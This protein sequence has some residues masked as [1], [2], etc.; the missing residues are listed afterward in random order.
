M[1]IYLVFLIFIACCAYP[2]IDSVP[3]FKNL[4]ITKKEAVDRCNFLY[5]NKKDEL[6]KCLAPNIDKIPNFSKLKLAE[7]NSIKL[8]KL[9]NTDKTDLI[10]CFVSFYEFQD[11]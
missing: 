6:V 10:E 2:D 7:G 4:N 1:K 5:E 8:C 9:I 11:K 3:N